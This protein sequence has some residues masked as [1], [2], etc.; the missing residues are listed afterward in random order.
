MFALALSLPFYA[1]QVNI[2]PRIKAP[3]SDPDKTPATHLKVDTSLVLVPITVTDKLGRPVLGLEKQDFRVFDN[4]VEQTITHLAME[5]DPVAVGFIFDISGS[6]GGNMGEYRMAAREFFKVADD[7]DEFFLVEFESKPRLA[8]PLSRDAANIDYQIMMTRSQGLTALFDAV[9]L[10]T[11][12]IRK[13]KLIKKAL[14]LI[15]DGGEN[16]SRYRQSEVESALRETDALLYAIGPSPDNLS[17]D[18]NGGLLKHLAEFTG[19]RL[20]ELQGTGFADLAQKVII[21]L[22]NRYLISYSPKDSARD[23][24][25]HAIKVQL[26]PPKGMGK[27]TAHWRTGYYAPTQ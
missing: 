7:D 9:Y 10:A 23:G 27:L 21:D 25:Y 26:I 3:R 24:K 2:E 15:S 19:G 6:I 1:Q 16:N 11:N 22:R 8:V 20:I 4:Q 14:I 12:E 5:D 13:S 17:G 18:N